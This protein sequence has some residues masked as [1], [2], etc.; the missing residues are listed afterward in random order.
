VLEYLAGETLYGLSKRHDVSRNVIRLWIARYEAGGAPND[1]TTAGDLLQDYKARIA[2][3]ERLAGKLAL[4][5]EFLIGASENARLGKARRRVRPADCP[6]RH[7]STIHPN[8]C[9][10]IRDASAGRPYHMLAMVNHITVEP[11]STIHESLI[12]GSGV[13][14]I[15]TPTLIIRISQVLIN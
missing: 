2:A 4:E 13:S 3:L 1:E 10:P 11:G 5:N 15:L 7:A 12:S 6:I 14:R 8:G 9:T